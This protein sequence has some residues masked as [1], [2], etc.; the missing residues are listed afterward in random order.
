MPLGPA[1]AGADVSTHRWCRECQ[2]LREVYWE[3]IV[4]VAQLECVRDSVSNEFPSEVAQ[5]LDA[6]IEAAEHA[7]TA[8]R[9]ALTTHRIEKEHS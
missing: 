4:E 1:A 5:S 9:D 7:R 8:A 3:A 2:Q 6:Q